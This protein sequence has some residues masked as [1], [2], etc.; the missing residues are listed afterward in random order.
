M[1]QCLSFT[2]YVSQ[3]NYSCYKKFKSRQDGYTVYK[4]L[5]NGN[6]NLFELTKKSCNQI[7]LTSYFIL[8]DFYTPYS[9]KLNLSLEIY[10]VLAGWRR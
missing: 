4:S 8:L 2:D 1:E 6:E 3:R 7:M 5:Q 10:R 9:M